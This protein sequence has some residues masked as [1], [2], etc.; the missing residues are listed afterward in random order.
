MTKPGHH[1]PTTLPREFDLRTYFILPPSSFRLHPYHLITYG[2][3]GDPTPPVIGSAG[4]T[5]MNS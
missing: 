3:T 1:F 2:L 4:A 5:N